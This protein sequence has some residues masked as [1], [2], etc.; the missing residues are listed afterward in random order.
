ME[1]YTRSEA[2][3]DLACILEE[4]KTEEVIVRR[5][6]GDMYAIVLKSG[7][8]CRSPFDVP[9]LGKR[10]TRRE[11]HEVMRESRERG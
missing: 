10:L 2:R 1:I 3:Q 11:K 7:W 8:P 6:K 4:S 9:G 5:R